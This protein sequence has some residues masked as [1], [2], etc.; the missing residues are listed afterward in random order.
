MAQEVEV[1]R[2]TE[3]SHDESLTQAKPPVEEAVIVIFGASGDLT[4]RKLIPALYQLWTKGFLSE[5]APIVGVAR[6]EKTDDAFRAE[7]AEAVKDEAPA[8]SFTDQKWATFA[9]RLF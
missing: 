7:M 5:R 1:K 9:K 3:R 4:A 8:G 2:F 6:R